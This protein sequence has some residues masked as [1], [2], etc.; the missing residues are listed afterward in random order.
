MLQ[1]TRRHLDQLVHLVHRHA[2]VGG[3]LDVLLLLGLGNAPRALARR[4][5]LDFRALGHV[6]THGVHHV[7]DGVVL[8]RLEGVV[9]LFGQPFSDPPSRVGEGQLLTRAV[10]AQLRVD[11]L[12]PPFLN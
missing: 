3:L 6:A 1:H 10:A 9:F 8:E 7:V 5:V 2:P 11:K 4:V 12:G